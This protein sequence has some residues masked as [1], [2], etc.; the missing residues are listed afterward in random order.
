MTKDKIVSQVS[1]LVSDGASVGTRASKAHSPVSWLWVKEDPILGQ[2]R[3][4]VCE[5]PEKTTASQMESPHSS[6][7]WV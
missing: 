1:E 3:K 6:N 7:T 4:P 2:T 5:V